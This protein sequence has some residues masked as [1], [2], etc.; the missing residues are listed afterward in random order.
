[1][2]LGDG[3]STESRLNA[4]LPS[5]VALLPNHCTGSSPLLA[6]KLPLVR[7]RTPLQQV[8][9][10]VLPVKVTFEYPAT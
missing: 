7:Q 5:G 9:A 8:C 3:K 4:S 10:L 6:S 1:M 2:K